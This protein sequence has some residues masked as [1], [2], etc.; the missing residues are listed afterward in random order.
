MDSPVES[1]TSYEFWATGTRRTCGSIRKGLGESF[2]HPVLATASPLSID[3][4]DLNTRVFKYS[5]INVSLHKNC[6][7]CCVRGDVSEESVA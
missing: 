5:Y 2:Y 3:D 4:K 6:R 1:Q 7:S